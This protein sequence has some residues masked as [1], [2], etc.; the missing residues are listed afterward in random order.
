MPGNSVPCCHRENP[1]APHI[2][3]LIRRPHLRLGIPTFEKSPQMTLMCDCVWK[4]LTIKWQIQGSHGPDGE[5]RSI[6]RCV[7]DCQIVSNHILSSL[8]AYGQPFAKSQVL[9]SIENTRRQRQPSP[10]ALCRLPRTPSILAFRA[11]WMGEI[12]TLAK[13]ESRLFIPETASGQAET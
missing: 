11:T 10:L 8:H 3:I 6:W 1:C 5:P 12:Q 2:E 7:T 13:W 9:N 4:T